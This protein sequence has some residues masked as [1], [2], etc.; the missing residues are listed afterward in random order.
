MAVPYLDTA[1]WIEDACKEY[2]NGRKV[3]GI[4]RYLK[5]MKNSQYNQK[6][7]FD[8]YLSAKNA[9]NKQSEA[10]DTDLKPLY[11]PWHWNRL[12]RDLDKERKLV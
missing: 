4:N 9:Y 10:N 2:P 7:R 1:V 12:Q 8:I 11:R 5:K 3:E 6:Y